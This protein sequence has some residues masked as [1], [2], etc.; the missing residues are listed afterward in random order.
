MFK[1]YR[2]P[3]GYQHFSLL[4]E[5]TLKPMLGQPPNVFRPVSVCL[6]RPQGCYWLLGLSKLPLIGY[7][8][9]LLAT[10]ALLATLCVQRGWFHLMYEYR[11][12][13]QD[14]STATYY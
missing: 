14:A 6:S 8:F 1:K 10:A 7:Y 11:N 9:V 5:L 2:V 3:I 13:N 4:S 12:M